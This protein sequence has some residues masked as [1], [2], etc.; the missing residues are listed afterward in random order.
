[1][2][3]TSVDEILQGIAGSVEEYILPELQ[4]PFAQSQAKAIAGILRNLSGRVEESCSALAQENMFYRNLLRR[5]YGELAK[6]AGRKCGKL[7]TMNRAFI[8]KQAEGRV[9]SHKQLRRENRR[10]R[11]ALS[12]IITVLETPRTQQE[13]GN[14]RLRRLRADINRFLRQE[15]RKEVKLMKPVGWREMASSNK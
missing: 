12:K 2:M 5:L 6:G 15:L 1:M 13:L 11:V 3:R 10:L 8:T 9:P 7:T 4:S 14:R